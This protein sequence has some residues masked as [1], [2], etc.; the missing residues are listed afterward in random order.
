[1]TKYLI[2]FILFLAGVGMFSFGRITEVY[3]PIKATSVSWQELF[4]LQTLDKDYVAQ[5]IEVYKHYLL[6]TV[7][8]KDQESRLLV[9]DMRDSNQLEYLFAVPFPKEATHVSDLSLYGHILYAIDY[10]SHNLYAIDIQ[11]TI[12]KRKMVI[13]NTIQTGLNRSG[14]I[15]VFDHKGQKRLAITQFLL[16]NLIQVFDFNTLEQSDKKPLASIKS[17]YFIQGLYR[18]RNTLLVSSNKSGKDVIFLTDFTRALTS[19]KL[20]NRS[21]IALEGPGRMIED[22]V[23]YDDHILTSDEETNT[24]FISKE[25]IHALH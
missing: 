14:S 1:M 19:G 25:P 13:S 5:G 23:L 16:N 11:D 8:K 7:H 21:T 15:I 2:I 24:I 12:T 3:K 18:D 22:I 4:K 17:K 20:M 9:F 10:A 6:F